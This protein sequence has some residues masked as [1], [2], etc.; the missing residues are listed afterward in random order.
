ML[1]ILLFS[2]LFS[3]L[4]FSSH[5]HLHSLAGFCKKTTAIE[6]HSCMAGGR[7]N[8]ICFTTLSF[9]PSFIREK[10]WGKKE[11]NFYNITTSFF[12]F[13]NGSRPEVRYKKKLRLGYR[14]C[15]VCC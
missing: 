12:F 1:M 13:E 7:Y 8:N 10:H 4:L 11:K 5:G 6:Q 2:S 14:Q 9:S 15:Q 3:F